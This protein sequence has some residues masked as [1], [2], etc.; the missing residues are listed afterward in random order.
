MFSKLDEL[1][2]KKISEELEFVSFL[3]MNFWNPSKSIE[4]IASNFFLID[5]EKIIDLPK[6]VFYS[7]LTNDKLTIESEDSLLDVIEEFMNKDKT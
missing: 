3:D 1:F 6:T 5:K 7:I 2:E 4:C